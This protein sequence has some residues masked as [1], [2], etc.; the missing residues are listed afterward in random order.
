MADDKDSTWI[1]DLF[2][3]GHFYAS[4][5]LTCGRKTAKD[6][7]AQWERNGYEVMVTNQP[8]STNS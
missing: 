5:S 1:F 6:A 8:K 2:K 3:N 4:R 7:Q